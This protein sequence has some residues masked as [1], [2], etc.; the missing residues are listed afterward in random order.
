LLLSL[1]GFGLARAGVGHGGT[2]DVRH[3][4]GYSYK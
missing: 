4:V 2:G 3:R 1:A